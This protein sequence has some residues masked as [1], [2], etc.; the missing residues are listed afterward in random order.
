MQ[1]YV[2][3]IAPKA[4]KCAYSRRSNIEQRELD[5]G[6]SNTPTRRYLV[7]EPEREHMALQTLVTLS[8]MAEKILGSS[9]LNACFSWFILRL[10][11]RRLKPSFDGDIDLLAGPLTWNDSREASVKFEE[12]R[13]LH[14]D[15]HPSQIESL[16]ARMLAESGAI[17]WPPSTNKLLAIE[18]KCAYLSPRA[19][20]VIREELKSTKTSRS[21]LAHTRAQIMSLLNLG[22]DRVILLDMIANPPMSGNGDGQPWIAAATLADMSRRAMLPDLKNRLPS[23]SPAGHFVWSI[24]SVAGGDESQRGA[25]VPIEIR[26]AVQNPFLERTD[27]QEN[28][29]TIEDNLSKELQRLPQPRNLSVL[30]QDCIN[31]GQIHSVADVC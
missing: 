15:W 16:T 6:I 14:P 2:A 24:G 22:F 30:F 13:R 31:C 7:E 28:R 23:N 5:L 20:R 17:K 18:A 25:G 19:Q 10:K 12:Q 4:L 1:N 21:K 29:A 11:K 9:Q 26:A 27:I 3:R 8:F